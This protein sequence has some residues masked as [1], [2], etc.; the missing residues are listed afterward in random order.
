MY[1][2][3]IVEFDKNFQIT[4]L[5][6]SEKINRELGWEPNEDFQSG[7]RKTVEWYLQNMEWCNQINTG[8]TKGQRLGLD[9][10][11]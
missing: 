4:R 9:K 3:S 6:N 5:I 7:L 11:S 8:I 10:K 2:V 1:D